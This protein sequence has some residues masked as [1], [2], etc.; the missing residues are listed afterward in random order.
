MMRK[1]AGLSAVATAF[2]VLAGSPAP[3]QL[4]I[5][6]TFTAAFNANFGANAVA[7]QNAWIA[8]ANVFTANFSDNIT[9]NITV[10]A[11]AGTSVFGESST[12]L[13]STS[14][15]TFHSLLVAD[16]KTVDDAVSVGPTG[17]VTAADPVGGTHTWWASRAEAKAIGFIASDLNNDGTTTFGAGNP[18]TFSGPIAAG[19]FDFQGVAAHE[20]AEVMGRIGISGGTI[21]SFP[22]SFSLLDLFSWT[23]AG[24][25]GLGPGPNEQFSIDQGTTLLKLYNNAAA[26]GFDTRDWAPG[27][28]DSFNQFADPGVVEPVT[29]VDLREMDV[30]GYDRVQA[31]PEPRI[32]ALA[33]ALVGLV[34]AWRRRRAV[35]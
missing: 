28:N 34:G 24:T 35:A 32:L 11:V 6:P 23:G 3:A 26:N 25:R 20:I 13:V 22:N 33:L 27:T 7:A 15:S 19:T 31:V 21:G 30:I 5:N 8:A 12:S 10:D 18:F 14:Y 17:S 29:D 16:A 1:L 2:T 4:V 9:I